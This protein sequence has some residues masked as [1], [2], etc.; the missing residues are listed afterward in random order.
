MDAAGKVGLEI[1]TGKTKILNNQAG[2]RGGS[3][4]IA[5]HSIEI[6]PSHGSTDYLGRKLCLSSLHDVEVDSRIDKAWKK[7][8]AFKSE[9]CNKH[10]RLAARLKLF[11]SVVTSCF[12]YGAGTW[13]LTA[14]REQRIRVAQRR[15]LR[16]MLG[17]GRR[18]SVSTHR[19]QRSNS[20]SEDEEPEPEDTEEDGDVQVELWSEWIR[21]TTGIAEDMLHK[22]GLDG[23]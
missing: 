5:G 17:A 16:W 21:R 19:E 15:M 3:M 2:S 1:H 10:Y 22:C 7:F 4:K 18:V 14:S 23:W 11:Q 8:F 6:L 13:T 12:T 9:L 20:S